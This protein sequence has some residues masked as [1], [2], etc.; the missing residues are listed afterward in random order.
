MQQ[1]RGGVS[2]AGAGSFGAAESNLTFVQN[3]PK[4][5]GRI[6][7]FSLVAIYLTL[8]VMVTLWPA[9]GF[10]A[11][12]K[13]LMNV[14]VIFGFILLFASPFYFRELRLFAILSFLFSLLSLG[15]LLLPT[16]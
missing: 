3:Q 16:L 6:L 2:I 14:T 4:S 10:W 5:L 15:M 1:R 13:W 11:L 8:F 9:S 12:A 7:Y